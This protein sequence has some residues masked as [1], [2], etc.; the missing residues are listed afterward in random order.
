MDFLQQLPTAPVNNSEDAAPNKDDDVPSAFNLKSLSAAKFF[1]TLY[2][3]LAFYFSFMVK[4]FKEA[5]P[6][7]EF[8]S[9]EKTPSFSYCNVKDNVLLNLKTY[10]SNYISLA[11]VFLLFSLFL[12][13]CFDFFLFCKLVLMAAICFGLK[14]WSIYNGD[15]YTKF[16]HT[17]TIPI[18]Y[19][20]VAVVVVFFLYSGVVGLLY[21][22]LFYALIFAA[23]LTALH[24]VLHEPKLSIP[25]KF[26]D[27]YKVGPCNV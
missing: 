17:I 4:K 6:W 14:M 10:Y 9:W 23:I 12:F 25:P 24:A 13:F 20:L 7:S 2:Q 8:Q 16:G 11:C 15:S 19:Q 18:D 26:D 3:T 27:L 5:R 1:F 22:A 21:S